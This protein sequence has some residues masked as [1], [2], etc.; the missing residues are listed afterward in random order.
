VAKFAER[1]RAVF[2]KAPTIHQVTL[3]NL[4]QQGH[5]LRE[6]EHLA[7]VTHLEFADSFAYEWIDGLLDCPHL[8]RLT[9]LTMTILPTG[10]VTAEHARR[11]LDWEPLGR[12]RS[13]NLVGDP[14]QEESLRPLARSALLANLHSLTLGYPS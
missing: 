1:G 3:A 2:R 8:T 10:T 14:L 9:R 13:L 12:L 5:R 6:C 7:R 11:L 4:S